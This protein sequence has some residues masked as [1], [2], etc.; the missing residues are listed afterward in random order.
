MRLFVAVELGEDVLREAATLV[1]ELRRRVDRRAPDAKL[2]WVT[3]E[4]MHLTLRFLGEVS[5]AQGGKM[6]AALRAP[7]AMAPFEVAWQGLGAFPHRGP[8]RVLWVGAGRGRDTLLALET[9]V[10]ARL[11]PLGF[12]SGARS[13]S[14][15]L[16]LA[17]VREARGLRTAALFEGIAGQPVGTTTVDAITLFQS[18]LSPKGPTYLAMDRTPLRG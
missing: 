9:A 18:K 7:I 12:E 2:T 11:E 14:P 6:L 4:R 17:R 15:H 3:P 10:S 5:D 8:P 1:G 13:Y 16:T